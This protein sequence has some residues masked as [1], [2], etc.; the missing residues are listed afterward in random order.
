MKKRT[1]LLIFIL[2]FAAWLRFYRLD[3]IPPSLYSDEAD[4]LYNAY[5]ILMTG[6]DEH[7]Q[8]IPV[9][10]RSFGDWKPP[11]QTYVMV[12]FVWILGPTEIAARLPSALA[13]LGIIILTYVLVQILL[14]QKMYKNKIALLAA[15]SLS[16]APWHILQ[17]RAAM[18][19][20]IA[21]FFYEA[22]VVTFIK[23]V[24]DSSS[25][26][27]FLRFTQ[28]KPFRPPP[29]GF[30]GE[31]FLIVSL[32]L[33]ALSTYAYYGMRIVVPLTILLLLF[34]HMKSIV[35]RFKVLLISAIIS[36]VILLPLGI[37]FLQEP[38]VVLGRARTV[39]VFYDQGIN[40]RRWELTTSDAFKSPLWLTRFFHNNYYLYGKDIVKRFFSHFELD[41][42][43]VKG[44]GAQPFQ[45]LNM[46]ILLAVDFFLLPI[47]IYWLIRNY[48]KW[49]FFAGVWIIAIAP[50][51]LTFLTPASNRT[52]SA[53]V[54]IA[55]VSASGLYALHRL[56]INNIFHIRINAAV[57]SILV[58]MSFAFF[59]K[60][61][62]IVIP[63]EHAN[64]WNWGWKEVSYYLK[65]VE[66]K[67]D[68]LIVYDR[69]MPYIYF[70]L[71]QNKNPQYVFQ[72]TVRTYHPDQFGFE[73]VDSLGKYLFNYEKDWKDLRE[74]M[75]PKSLYVVPSDLAPENRNYIHAIS[76]P[77]GKPAFYFFEN[78]KN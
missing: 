25:S 59:I 58:A 50:A 13:G 75:L 2:F 22:G 26:G 30:S 73:H 42:L 52:F 27:A 44:D 33:L 18:L 66:D 24:T 51:A 23:G 35:S 28:D 77:D 32:P 36:L 49:K 38:D 61:Y 41:Y 34:M 11:L 68:N 54:P 57:I 72:N 70:A 71:Y 53:S 17:S 47:G 8:F 15:F 6:K 16:V 1:R 76:Y 63:L 39:S 19:V 60:Q 67:Y 78:D 12:P 7:G 64:W 4:Q 10:F 37:T 14:E 62:F 31:L 74:N 45:I 21:L 48:A 40:L 46:G 20:M 65:S 5:S 69:G 29:R 9:S 3:S 56:S 55:I 43:F